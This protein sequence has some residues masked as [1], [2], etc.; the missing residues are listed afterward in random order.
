VPYI[1]VA[2]AKLLQSEYCGECLSGAESG[3]RHN[4]KPQATIGVTGLYE[5]F[6][7]FGVWSLVVTRAVGTRTSHLLSTS[8]L[9]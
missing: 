1:G 2:V 7:R 3:R 5:H 4:R 8:G 9:R 6:C